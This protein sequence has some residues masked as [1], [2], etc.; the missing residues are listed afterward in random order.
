[1][2]S[3]RSDANDPQAQL[4]AIAGAGSA[5]ARRLYTPWWYHPAI[6]LLLTA[7]IL[8]LGLAPSSILAMVTVLVLVSMA[9]IIAAYRR[10]TGV[11]LIGKDGTTGT[12]SPRMRGLQIGVSLVFALGFAVVA[13]IRFALDGSPAWLVV[14]IA[15]A[16]PVAY[17]LLGRAYD[18][19]LRTHLRGEA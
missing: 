10:I 19:A 13:I 17:T 16:M 14:A 11:A 3:N 2:E 7:L 1:M 12:A 9:A 8:A 4:D 6:G 18:R 15:A 5:M